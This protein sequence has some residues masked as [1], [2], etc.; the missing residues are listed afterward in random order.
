MLQEVINDKS[1]NHYF[2]G[3]DTMSDVKKDIKNSGHKNLGKKK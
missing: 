3:L 2:A 1:R